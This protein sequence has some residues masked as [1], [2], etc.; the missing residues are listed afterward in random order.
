ML[1]QLGGNMIKGSTIASFVNV[2]F[3]NILMK[4]LQKKPFKFLFKIYTIM[5]RFVLNFCQK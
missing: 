5:L 2:N 3:W 1:A 4:S